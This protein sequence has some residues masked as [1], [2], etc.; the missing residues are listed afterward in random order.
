MV[1]AVLTSLSLVCLAA[2]MTLLATSQAL[3]RRARRYH[4]GMQALLRLGGRGLE[5]LEI[6]PLAWPVLQASGW[7]HLT[8]TGHWFGHAVTSELGT[9]GI[10]D[11]K[12]LPKKG[13]PLKFNVGA[14]PDVTL[15]IVLTHSALRGESRMF[16]EQLAR[17]FILLLEDALRA[18]TEAISLALAERA[19]LTLYLQHDMRNLAQW[20]GWVCTDFHDCTDSD[21]LLTAARRL[22]RNAP[23]ARERA[24]KLMASLG[25]SPADESPSEVDLREAVL[26]AAQLAGV[27]VIL[28]GEAKAWIAQALLARALDNLFSNLAPNWRDPATPKPVLQI[29]PAASTKPEARMTAVHFFSPWPDSTPNLSPEK[30][31]EPFASGRTGGLGLGLYQARK[32]LREAGGDLTAQFQDKGLLF[33]LSIPTLEGRPA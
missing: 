26:K 30:L 12:R 29:T 32:S 6:P 28:D 22:Q 15:S 20:V 4:N 3:S 8:L 31:F 2:G 9:P 21:A 16:A 25:K 13:P 17:V 11:R 33:L 10:L 1:Y 14:G 18:R 23:L 24:Q 27:E 7:G 19:R 5:P